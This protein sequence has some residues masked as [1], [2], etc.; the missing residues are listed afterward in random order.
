MIQDKV[1][2]FIKYYLSF[3]IFFAGIDKK[4]DSHCREQILASLY[5]YQRP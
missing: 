4:T 2:V 5:P 1:A 3:K